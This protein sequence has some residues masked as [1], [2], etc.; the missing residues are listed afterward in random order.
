MKNWQSKSR[1]TIIGREWVALG[2]IRTP[3]DE[4]KIERY[5]QRRDP[6]WRRSLRA[7]GI[8]AP[9]PRQETTHD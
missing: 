8:T 7:L 3:E 9:A 6:L 4:A 2:Y 1:V 5:R